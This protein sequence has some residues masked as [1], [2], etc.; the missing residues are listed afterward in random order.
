MQEEAVQAQ[1]GQRNTG[2]GRGEKA[3]KP[4][5]FATSK[6]YNTSG[7]EKTCKKQ[8]CTSQ[9]VGLRPRVCRNTFIDL[10]VISIMTSI[11]GVSLGLF[12][13]FEQ[14]QRVVHTS[15]LCH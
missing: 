6:G 3:K 2:R 7:A 8:K 14:Q 5:M 13:T 15:M 4:K 11:V 9:Y 1:K 12:L 10:S